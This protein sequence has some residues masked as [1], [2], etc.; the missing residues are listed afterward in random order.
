MATARYRSMCDYL[1]PVVCYDPVMVAVATRSKGRCEAVWGGV[2][3]VIA[4]CEFHD[5]L[6]GCSG[7]K[8]MSDKRTVKHVCRDCHELLHEDKPRIRRRV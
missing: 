8:P 4:A 1:Q 7:G 5:V 6:N 2:R 3:C